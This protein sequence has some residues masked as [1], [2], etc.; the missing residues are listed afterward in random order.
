[1]LSVAGCE[2]PPASGDMAVSSMSSPPRI[3]INEDIE[4]MPEV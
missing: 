4:A 2:V 1:M 3:A